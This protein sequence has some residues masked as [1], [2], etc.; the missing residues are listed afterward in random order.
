MKEYKIKISDI[1][2]YSTTN[3][4]KDFK[5]NLAFVFEIPTSSIGIMLKK[6]NTLQTFLWD[7][8]PIISEYNFRLIDTNYVLKDTP[9]DKIIKTSNDDLNKFIFKYTYL[10]KDYCVVYAINDNGNINTT[11]AGGNDMYVVYQGASITTFEINA[12][13]QA[14]PIS[15]CTTKFT[16][17][18][19]SDLTI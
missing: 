5:E 17:V 9:H 18:I 13:I 12:H 15:D 6:N 14:R 8:I 3:P 10:T 7:D 2:N 11:I 16:S 1:F 19:T 4:Y